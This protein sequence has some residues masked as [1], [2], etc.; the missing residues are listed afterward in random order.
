MKERTILIELCVDDQEL[1][2]YC[3]SFILYII[4]IFYL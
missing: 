4:L 2:Q 3:A 1:A